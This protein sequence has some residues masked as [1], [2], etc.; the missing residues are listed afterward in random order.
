MF[1]Q[2]RLLLS[3]IVKPSFKNSSNFRSSNGKQINCAEIKIPV[4]WGHVAGKW[5]GP[6]DIRP[7]LAIHGWQDNCG[8]FNRLLPLI[9]QDVGFLAIDLP[10]HGYSSHIPDGFYYHN[11][12][13]MILV[14]RLVNY[15]KWPQVSLLAHSLGGSIAFLYAIINPQNVD[16]LIC[17]DH[18]K[19]FIK[20]KIISTNSKTISKFLQ[21]EELERQNIEPPAYTMEEIKQKISSS[22]GGS[23]AYEHSHHLAERNVAP[24]KS[25]PGKYYFTRDPRL[26]ETELINWRQEDLV[27]GARRVRC[28]V[29]IAK[30][31]DGICFEEA[32]NVHEVVDALKESGNCE[33]HTLEGT[34]HFHLN[35]P[36]VLA[37]LIK[38]FLEQH[39]SDRS[40][41]GIKGEMI[42]SGRHKLQE[43]HF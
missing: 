3:T 8:T 38:K 15:F 17:L 6:T 23:V 37:G 35:N 19:P 33:L 36:E 30:A 4:P 24:S 12:N 40:V 10:G 21:Y 2:G 22:L 16:L 28:P 43:L 7:I 26:K 20:N 18:V 39:R 14:Q 25:Q 32:K 41:G 13:Y 1:R 5:W 27:S 31:I 29:F 9:T 34:H 42:V 11:I